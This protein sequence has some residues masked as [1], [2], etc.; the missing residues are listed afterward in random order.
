M[1]FYFTGR[2]SYRDQFCNME[3]HDIQTKGLIFEKTISRFAYLER[4]ESNVNLSY[5]VCPVS[6]MQGNKSQLKKNVES[7]SL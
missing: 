5:F 2:H 7:R 4:K 1:N 6:S 3:T